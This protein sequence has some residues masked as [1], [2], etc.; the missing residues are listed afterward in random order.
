MVTPLSCSQ[1]GASLPP[2]TL[3][4]PYAVCAYCKTA[5]QVS[6]PAAAAAV[7]ASATAPAASEPTPADFV[8]F[9]EVF[10]AEVTRSK[11][12]DAALV[13]AARVAFGRFGDTA[14]IARAVARLL[15]DFARSSGLDVSR[16][17]MAASRVFQAYLKARVA[18]L[19]QRQ[20]TELNLPFLA[21]GPKG[22]AHLTRTLEPRDFAD[23]ER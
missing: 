13:E 18:A 16:D 17:A 5:M 6:L 4:S 20:S 22:P 9:T 1:C 2:P 19:A 23:L 12:P 15:A 3:G 21:A 10:A 8:R 7:L 11:R 14:G